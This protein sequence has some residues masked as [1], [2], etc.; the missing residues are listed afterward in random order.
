[1]NRRILVAAGLAAI[2]AGGSAAAL[3]QPDQGGR[4]PHRGP[5]GGM[6]GG[7][8]DLGLR[9]LDLTD[10]QRDQVRA[11]MESHKAAFGEAR[12]KLRDAHRAMHQAIVAQPV[13]EA[14]IRAKSAEVGAAMADDAILR[15][16]VRAEVFALL[17]P[18]QQQKAAE[19]NQ[20]AQ[21]RRLRQPR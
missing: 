7:P 9:G 15:A 17:T 21:S 14:A 10:A 11:I 2:L 5:R 18:E 6:I 12:T 3:A 4:G 16:K 8:A 1:M 19:R 13:D 20:A